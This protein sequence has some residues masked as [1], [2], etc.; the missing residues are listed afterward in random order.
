MKVL[1]LTVHFPPNVG[2]VETHLADL[3]A[4]LLSKNWQIFVLCYQP[5][6][7]K[8]GWKLY[9]SRKNFQIFRIPWLSGLFYKFIPYPM[10]EFLYLFPGLFIAAPFVLLRFNP[11]VIH[12]HG[13][14]A[15]L[16]AVIW[17]RIFRKRIIVSVHSL[18]SFPKQGMYFKLA[19][20]IFSNSDKTLCLSDKSYKEIIELGVSKSNI[21]KFTYWIDL[22]KF[23]RVKKVE[24]TFIKWK[25]KFAVLFVGRLISEKGINVLLDSV[26]TWDKNIALIFAGTGPLEQEI[27]KAAVSDSRI[28]YVGKISQD[29]LPQI[30]SSVNITIVPSISEEGFGRVIM[31]S[32]ACQTPV[33]GSKKGSISEAMDESVGRLIDINPINIKK[34]VEYYYK[35]PKA[36][37]RL[38]LAARDFTER[39]YSSKN[40][41]TIINAY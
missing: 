7:V 4:F 32:L 22:L 14:V 41:E 9:E 40:A 36:L 23:R 6:S 35:N 21:E 33:I 25:E 1:Q 20:F 28:Y 38:S 31:E 3:A 12:A 11:L 18:Y 15:G 16:S 13:L 5:L 27:Q 10:L 26:K 2:G 17:G 34:A 30:Y 19:K 39:R 8:V 24:K 29:Q 37:K